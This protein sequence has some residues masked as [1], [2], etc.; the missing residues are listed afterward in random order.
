MGCIRKILRI[1]ANISGRFTSFSNMLKRIFWSFVKIAIVWC[2][3]ILKKTC[4]LEVIEVKSHYYDD[5]KKGRFFFKPQYYD[6]R[7]FWKTYE[8]E[9]LSRQKHT[10]MM[11]KKIQNF[12]FL[13]LNHHTMMPENFGKKNRKN[14]LLWRDQG[15][16]TILW[17]PKIKLF[18]DLLLKSRK[19]DAQKF[20]KK[21]VI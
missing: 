5:N 9:G 13:S 17:C 11:A 16:N 7:K 20:W 15:N 14:I 6:A 10:T 8:C 19:Y 1:I 21:H 2:S 4:N 18:F 3:K 12:R